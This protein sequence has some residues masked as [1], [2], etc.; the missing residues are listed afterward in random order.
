MSMG[1]SIRLTFALLSEVIKKKFIKIL[2]KRQRTGYIIERE[3]KNNE[4][5]SL[6]AHSGLAPRPKSII[7]KKEIYYTT[8]RG[9]TMTFAQAL[10]ALRDTGTI[11][12]AMLAPLG[13]NMEHFLRFSALNALTR[14]WYVEQLIRHL[15]AN[16]R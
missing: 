15:E 8:R 12:T 3:G 1:P 7:N 4:T 16:P 11:T 14:K 10:N 13:M 9:Y 6:R 5:T 2:D